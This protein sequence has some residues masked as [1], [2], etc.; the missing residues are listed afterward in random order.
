MKLG[1][2]T[3]THNKTPL[4]KKAIALFEREGCGAVFH[5]GDF[6]SDRIF[7]LFQDRPF[8]FHFVTDHNSHDSRMRH[9]CDALDVSVGGL[10]IAMYHDTY[11]PVIIDG[12]EFGVRQ[13]ILDGRYDLVIYGHLHYFNLKQAA[14]SSRTMAINSGGLYFPELS[15]VAVLDTDAGTVTMFYWFEKAFIPTLRFPFEGKIDAFEVV[16]EAAA[17]TFA[18]ALT[19]LRWK[20]KDRW[21]YAFSDLDNEQ[22]FSRNYKLLFDRLGIEDHPAF[23]Y[24]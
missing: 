21:E 22:W 20:C 1:L 5:A 8:A 16:H 6:E 4:V 13:N 9:R 11:Q 14:R 3:D 15:T 17:C 10:R 12:R 2:I 7:K 23:F 18:D 24:A 19:R